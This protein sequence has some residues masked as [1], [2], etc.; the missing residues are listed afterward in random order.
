MHNI[1]KNVEDVDFSYD[2]ENDSIYAEGYEG[3]YVEVAE[4]E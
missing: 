4:D 2:E 1:A 3:I